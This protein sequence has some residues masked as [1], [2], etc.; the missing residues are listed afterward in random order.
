MKPVSVSG[1]VNGNTVECETEDYHFGHR[2]SSQDSDS[3]VKSAI[4][5]FWR[6]FN[7]L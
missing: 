6:G 3:L 5:S 7:L 4:N 2:V 1:S